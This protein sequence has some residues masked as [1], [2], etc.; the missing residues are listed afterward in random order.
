MRAKNDV[1]DPD[2]ARLLEGQAFKQAFRILKKVGRK[3]GIRSWGRVVSRLV[4]WLV[5]AVFTRTCA[6]SQLDSMLNHLF[7]IV[8][9]ELK[10]V[11]QKVGIDFDLG[12]GL[13]HYRK[14]KSDIDRIGLFLDLVDF[15]RLIVIFVLA[16]A[17]STGEITG[18]DCRLFLG[19]GSIPL[20][21]I[22]LSSLKK[23]EVLAEKVLT[24]KISYKGQEFPLKEAYE[25]YLKS[26][27]LFLDHL[28]KNGPEI[29]KQ[30]SRFELEKIV[31]EC[32]EQAYCL[33]ISFRIKDFE[34]K[35]EAI[36]LCSNEWKFLYEGFEDKFLARKQARK[37]FQGEAMANLFGEEEKVVNLFYN[38]TQEKYRISLTKYQKRERRWIFYVL[39]IFILNYN[40]NQSYV[41][42][43]ICDFMSFLGLK[44]KRTRLLLKKM[45]KRNLL[46]RKI[47]I[48]MT[49]VFSLNIENKTIELLINLLNSESE[50]KVDFYNIKEIDEHHLRL[51]ALM[52]KQYLLD[53]LEKSTILRID[54][55]SSTFE[56]IAREF[57]VKINNRWDNYFD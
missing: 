20:Y 30:L 43:T 46:K 14:S 56:S 22:K 45:H 25:D 49:Y 3:A 15:V 36:D 9:N 51:L 23:F 31:E 54:Q 19:R 34:E 47:G 57:L 37:A 42:Y 11:H 55:N 27:R 12:P 17:I 1:T 5:F 6:Y 24:F 38:S 32:L 2:A 44:Y 41:G 21:D 48:N 28:S 13:I 52:M 8:L 50:N 53:F 18:K 40:K 4:T 7:K 26:F 39:L 16:D 35:L 10:E 29:L 33:P